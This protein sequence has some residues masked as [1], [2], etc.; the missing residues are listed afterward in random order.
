MFPLLLVLTT[1]CRGGKVTALTCI[2]QPTA[3]IAF[4]TFIPAYVQRDREQDIAY[5]LLF[6]LFF[7]FDTVFSVMN[8]YNNITWVSKAEPCR[9]C[10]QSCEFDTDIACRKPIDYGLKIGS[11][12]CHQHTM[13]FLGYRHF[14]GWL[15]STVVRRFGLARRWR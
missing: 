11:Q 6:L 2:E 9:S 12:A 14:D 4:C 13:Q 1:R 10:R 3:L 8:A 7:I 5:W 15:C